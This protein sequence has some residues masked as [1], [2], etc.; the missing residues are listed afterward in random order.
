MRRTKETNDSNI[1]FA[2]NGPGNR[3]AGVDFWSGCSG[4]GREPGSG[5]S[6]TCRGDSYERQARGRPRN[7]G[8]KKACRKS[9]KSHFDVPEIRVLPCH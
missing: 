1:L 9:I 5:W 3:E 6:A 2:A 4:S 8:R 7:M